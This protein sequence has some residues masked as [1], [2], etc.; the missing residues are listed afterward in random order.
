MSNRDGDAFPLPPLPPPCKD[1][2]RT[3]CCTL[4]DGW[5]SGKTTYVPL[6]DRMEGGSVAMDSVRNT[7][8]LQVRVYRIQYTH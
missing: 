6:L 1:I 2:A 8:L 7:T 3:L 5:K 4:K